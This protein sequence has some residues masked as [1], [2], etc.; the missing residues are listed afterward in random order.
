MNPIFR[1]YKYRKPRPMTLEPDT[2]PDAPV[3]DEGLT[4][5]VQGKD[6]SDLE[7]RMARAL[8]K[9]GISYR[10]EYLV[11]TAFTLPNELKQVDF[12]T[13]AG[14]P[15]PVEVDGEW[16]HKSAEQREYD[17]ER[18]AQINEALAPYGYLP[19]LRVPGENLGTQDFADTVVGEYIA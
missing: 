3:E 15:M 16:V 19:V 17:R 13:Y 7:E 14:Q 5:L 6:A 12:M 9:Y 10:Y 18:D 1:P 11:E 4:G 2:T 8:D